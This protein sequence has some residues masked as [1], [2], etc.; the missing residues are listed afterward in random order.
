MALEANL[1]QPALERDHALALL[2]EMLR[3]RRFEEK[4]AELYS[5]AKIRGFLHLYIGEEA[6]AVGALKALEADDAIVEA[7]IVGHLQGGGGKI[8]AI[9]VTYDVH[10]EHIGQETESN[11]TAG[12][13]RD[14]IGDNGSGSHAVSAQNSAMRCLG[15]STQPESQA[16]IY[17]TAHGGGVCPAVVAQ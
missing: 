9:E 7:E 17:R 16:I 11:A 15:G 12:A 1:T 10:H 4:C 13:A 8:V 2:R 5:A 6:V 3:I 14:I